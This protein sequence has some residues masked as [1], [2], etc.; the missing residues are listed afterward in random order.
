MLADDMGED[1]AVAGFYVGLVDLVEFLAEVGL[2]LEVLLLLHFLWIYWWEL[3]GIISENIWLI[4]IRS[5]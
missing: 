1:V 5:E 2:F 3:F 4:L